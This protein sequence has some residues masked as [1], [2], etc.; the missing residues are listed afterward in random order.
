MASTSVP[1]IGIKIQCPDKNKS[2]WQKILYVMKTFDIKCTKLTATEEGFKAILQHESDFDRLFSQDVIS[3]LNDIRCTIVK[4]QFLK[5]DRTVIVK[6]VDP[7]IME[8]TDQEICDD[9]NASNDNLEVVSFVRFPSDKTFKIELASK[10]M[11]NLCLKTGIKAF[12][13]YISS[14]YLALENSHQ[15]TFCFRCYTINNHISSACPKPSTYK[16]C[17]LCAKHDHTYKNCGSD[18]RTCLNCEGNHPTMS[19]ACSKYKEALRNK[20]DSF[21]LAS[22]I[23]SSAM[24]A[25][26]EHLSKSRATTEAPVYQPSHHSLSRED[27]FRGY[28]SLLLASRTEKD[29]F[30]TNL[31]KLLSANNLPSF[32]TAGLSFSEPQEPK[33][34][35]TTEETHE[36]TLTNLPNCSQTVSNQIEV[37]ENSSN[38]P[39]VSGAEE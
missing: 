29:D 22:K 19:K 7:F 18:E 26:Q 5:A 37:F 13:L 10:Q 27:M 38:E 25:I 11:T 15:V 12:N 33:P 16:V 8:H 30:Q 35:T 21:Q 4:P 34:Y 6:N 28:M 32:N 23:S 9:L 20:T 31:S 3:Q 1:L 17:S 14:N 24:P 2:A 39:V 36:S